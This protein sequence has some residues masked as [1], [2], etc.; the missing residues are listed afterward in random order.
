MI[1]DS[2][3]CHRYQ[4]DAE[5]DKTGNVDMLYALIIPFLV[6]NHANLFSLN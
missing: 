5:A 4:W 2:E 6:R 3:I 1:L